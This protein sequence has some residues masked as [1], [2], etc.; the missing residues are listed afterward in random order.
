MG[1][2]LQ[3]DS[4]CSLSEEIFPQTH[5]NSSFF[6]KTH[7]KKWSLPLFLWH[8]TFSITE[9]SSQMIESLCYSVLMDC[10][11][12]SFRLEYYSLQIIKCTCYERIKFYC[13][14]CQS[15][16]HEIF[17][18]IFCEV[19]CFIW[20]KKH[21]TKVNWR[22]CIDTTQYRVVW[23]TFEAMLIL[24]VHL[25]AYLFNKQVLIFIL[26]FLQQIV[27][28]IFWIWGNGMCLDCI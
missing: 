16:Y 19:G 24:C 22:A 18:Y 2:L 21:E 14:C 10:V 9:F 8:W 11:L 4:I 6:F 13:H 5:N 20:T 26:I 12:N 1:Y 23:T 27:K 28:H 25:F 17:Q 3:F 15:T 7:Y